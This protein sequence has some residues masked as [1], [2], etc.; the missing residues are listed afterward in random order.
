MILTI[1]RVLCFFVGLLTFL[2]GLLMVLMKYPN[3]YSLTLLG[4]LFMLIS[5]FIYKLKDKFPAF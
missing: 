2:A 4:F 3:S 5:V 1:L